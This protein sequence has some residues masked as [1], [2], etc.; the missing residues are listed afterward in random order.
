MA[1]YQLFQSP[2][3][4]EP[5]PVALLAALRA[6]DASAGVQHDVGG[7]YNVKKATAWTPQQITFVQNAIDTAPALTVERVAQNQI[8]QWPLALQALVLALIDQI[9][10][11]R[12]ALPVPLPA[13]TPA[14]AL[15]AVRAKAG[16][17]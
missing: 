15:A 14:Q 12:A 3:T 11:L 16:T 6:Q 4:T 17:L 10:V 9:N 5:D 8:D 1:F 2:R 7:S 13:I